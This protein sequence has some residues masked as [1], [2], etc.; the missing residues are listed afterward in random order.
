MGDAQNQSLQV[1]FN[2]SPKI[3]RQSSHVASDSGLVLVRELGQRLGLKT[4]VEE[5]LSDSRQVLNKQFALSNLLRQSV[6]SR[7]DV[8]M[9][10]YAE[11]QGPGRGAVITSRLDER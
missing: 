4:L 3:D 9:N 6:Y 11:D 10:Q 1:S 5:E 7:F 8:P 2:S